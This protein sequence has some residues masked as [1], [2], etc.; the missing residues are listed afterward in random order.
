MLESEV[1]S[2]NKELIESLGM[3]D[4]PSGLVDKMLELSIEEKKDLHDQLRY[5]EIKE[6][7]DKKK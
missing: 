5:R 7:V 2:T 4:K 3:L 6:T 1:N